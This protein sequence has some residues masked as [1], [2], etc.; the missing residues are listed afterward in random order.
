M[1][2]WMPIYVWAQTQTRVVTVCV[3]MY[4]YEGYLGIQ[5]DEVTCK[6]KY[7]ILYYEWKHN[8]VNVWFLATDWSF[9][10]KHHMLP[11]ATVF[12]LV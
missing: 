8:A 3:C 6:Q 7:V 1:A 9:S 11:G 10:L 12:H 4:V 5:F 2:C